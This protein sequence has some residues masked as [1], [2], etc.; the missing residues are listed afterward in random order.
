MK[1]WRFWISSWLDFV[2]TEPDCS[3]GISLTNKHATSYDDDAGDDDDDDDNDDDDD[4]DDGAGDGDAGDDD[5]SDGSGDDDD[6][7]GNDDYEMSRMCGL[8]IL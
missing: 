5:D 3:V 1:F 8:W 7:D 6:D 2:R 4:D